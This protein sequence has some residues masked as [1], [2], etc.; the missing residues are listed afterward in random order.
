MHGAAFSL[1]LRLLLLIAVA[2]LPALAVSWQNAEARRSDAIE[3]VHHDT[4][5]SA[6]AAT[7][8][9]RG[10]FETTRQLLLFIGGSAR[11]HS[12]TNA[13]CADALPASDGTARL[14]SGIGII[15][16]DGI[17]ACSS[18][19]VPANFSVAGTSSFTRALASGRFAVGDFSVSRL[20]G[21]PTVGV[22]QPIFHP[23]GTLALLV[24]GAVD[25]RVLGQAVAMGT[26]GGSVVTVFDRHGTIL[27]RQPGHDPWVGT[28]LP[29]DALVD[30]LGSLGG[31]VESN[32]VDGERRVYATLPMLPGEGEV[33]V[34]VGTPLA[35]A[36]FPIE[37]AFRRDLLTVAAVGALAFALAWF[38]SAR[39]V[40][41]PLQRL[42]AAARQLADGHLDARTGL[43]HDPGEVGRLAQSFDDMAGSVQHAAD[44]ERAARRELQTAHDKLA[45]LDRF[46]RSFVN[47][48]AHELSNPLTPMVLQIERLHSERLGLLNPAQRRAMDMVDRNALRLQHLVRDVLD[49]ARLQ[50]DGLALECR[51]VDLAP[52]IAEAAEQFREPAREG[53]LALT[54]HAAPRLV[55]DADPAR[56]SQVL[57]NLLS[58]AL[59]F[60]PRGGRVRLE[61][62]REGETAVVRVRDDG[63]GF[64]A[65][66]APRLFQ[67]FSRLKQSVTA[68]GTGLGL[69]I[70]KG[71]VERHGGTM[72]AESEGPGQGAIFGFALPLL[73]VGVPRPLPGS[74][75]E[76]AAPAPTVAAAKGPFAVLRREAD[77]SPE[78]EARTG[79]WAN[80]PA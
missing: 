14:L 7:M 24:G 30:R 71:I 55:V 28:V 9:A 21:Q 50:G 47:S 31:T 60:T 37:A 40:A 16:S 74:L 23:N 73:G 20:T 58:N 15:R 17:V 76:P 22:M 5:R 64:A 70:C 57:F 11:A 42:G 35:A 26:P 53:G 12:L 13:T 49:A 51:P 6:E 34:S 52:L 33:Y 45:E 29:L 2:L 78:P 18:N 32:G 68:S 72:W 36:L 27:T 65:E 39:W 67:S 25:L 46:R 79:P 75:V 61:A 63:I 43:R 62:V 8:A 48:A 4:L 66:E 1:R 44:G 19:P 56:V 38:A 54:A 69:F 77:A 3:A 41:K 80:G 10:S 59:K